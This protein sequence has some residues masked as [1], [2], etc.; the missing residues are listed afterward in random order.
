MICLISDRSGRALFGTAL[1]RRTLEIVATLR[2]SPGGGSGAFLARAA[3]GSRWYVKPINNLQGGKVIVTEYVV[4]SVGKLIG[5][6]VCQVAIGR[7]TDIIAGWEFCP[8]EK[9]KLV[10]GLAH[11][12]LLVPNATEITDRLPFRDKDENSRWHAGMIALYD[13]CWGGDD[14]WLFC[15]TEDRRIYSHDHGWYFPDSGC[16][17]SEETLVANVDQP[18]P[19]ACSHQGLQEDA[20]TEYALRLEQVS[21]EALSA[22]LRSVPASWSVTDAELEALGFFLER[23]APAV[24]GRLRSMIGGN[25]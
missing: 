17:W 8:G 20:L 3:D 15:E 6:P 22:I 14:Q 2:Q 18:R 10:P 24:A 4:G 11:M 12:S 13:W 1:T 23:R 19:L 25:P 16:D 5:A 21:Q 7:I 9:E